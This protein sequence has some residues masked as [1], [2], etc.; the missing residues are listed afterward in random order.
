MV[1]V[2]IASLASAGYATDAPEPTP[3][4]A[5]GAIRDSRDDGDSRYVVIDY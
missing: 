5:G 4:A 1:P 3:V 2:Q